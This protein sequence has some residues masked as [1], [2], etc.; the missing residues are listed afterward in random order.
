MDNWNTS[1]LINTKSPTLSDPSAMPLQPIYIIAVK[2]LVNIKF[3]P[4]FKNA[5]EV[6]IL[7]DA[8]WYLVKAS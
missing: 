7:I 4:E 5:R 8:F 3:W 6:A 1:W 2:A